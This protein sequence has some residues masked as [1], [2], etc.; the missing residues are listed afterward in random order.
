[1]TSQS[2][3]GYGQVMIYREALEKAGAADRRKV[4]EAIRRWIP[5]PALPSTSMAR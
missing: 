3:D 2:L 1:M 5:I 4:A